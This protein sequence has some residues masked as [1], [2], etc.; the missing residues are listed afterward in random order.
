[1]LFSKE[2]TGTYGSNRT[3]CTVLVCNDT[4]NSWYV[5]Q[6]GTIVNGTYDDGELINGV[7]VEEINDFDCFT[8]HTP[9][10]TLEE[11]EAC[12]EAGE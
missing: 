6:G 3:P 10:N 5:V 2:I 9:I 1:M 4:Y 12:I 8:W 11:L 7:N